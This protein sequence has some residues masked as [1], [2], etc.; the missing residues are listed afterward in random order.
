MPKIDIYNPDKK[1]VGELELADAVFG[2]EV[3]EHLLY[4]AVRYQRAKARAGTHKSKQR[5]DVRGGGRKPWRQKGTGRAR[6]GHS[7]SPHW[8]G[9]GTVFGPVVRSHAM[10]LNKQVRAAALCSALSRRVEE[11]AVL[12]LDDFVLPEIK[13]RQITEF[14]KRFEL[15]D[16]LLLTTPNGEDINLERSARNLGAVT[17]LRPEG[18][19]VYDVLLHKHL[20][21]TRSAVDA[22]TT[23][24]GGAE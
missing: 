1:K 24:L 19:N 20:V 22:L 23:R 21:L 4:A 16:M 5:S 11:K 3:R 9:G 6:Q 14:M 17:L 18:V 10:K 8:R 7:R 15:G 12:V 13:T 2:T